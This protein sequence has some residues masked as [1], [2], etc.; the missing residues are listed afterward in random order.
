MISSISTIVEPT[1]VPYT[2]DTV[3]PI[4]TQSI[5]Y[6]QDAMTTILKFLKSAELESTGNIISAVM[7]SD[8][9]K[10]I[11]NTITMATIIENTVLNS[12]TFM[13]IDF[14]NA[15]SKVIENIFV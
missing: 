11:D 15:S 9:T 14:E 13:P 12:S 4:E 5:W 1:G 7:R 10:F 3:S 6:I 8:P 2:I